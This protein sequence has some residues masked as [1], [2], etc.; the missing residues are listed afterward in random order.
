MKSLFTKPVK[1]NNSFIAQYSPVTACLACFLILFAL[2]I[3]NCDSFSGGSV[4]EFIAFNTG[5]ASVKNWS[6]VADTKHSKI[7]DKWIHYPNSDALIDI[8]VQL[9]NPLD[10]DLNLE[11]VIREYNGSDWLWTETPPPN[12]PLKITRVNNSTVKLRI[13][14]TTN[15]L[16]KGDSFKIRIYITSRDGTRDFGY[17]DLPQ[18]VYD[19]QLYPAFKLGIDTSIPKQPMA[20]WE[21]QNK[22]EHIGINKISLL[23]VSKNSDFQKGEWI[24]RY[25]RDTEEWNLTN[26][27]TAVIEGYGM[28]NPGIDKKSFSLPFPMEGSTDF[29]YFSDNYDFFVTVEDKNGVVVKASLNGVNDLLCMEN[30]RVEHKVRS[31]D[32]YVYEDDPFFVYKSGVAKYY[33]IVPYAVDGIRITATKQ[34]PDNQKVAFVP[35]T[36][37]ESGPVT[38]GLSKIGALNDIIMKVDWMDTESGTAETNTLYTFSVYRNLPDRDSA[39]KALQV[40]GDDGK[41]YS[42]SPLFVKPSDLASEQNDIINNYTV[43]VP[44][45]VGKVSFEWN[46]LST[47]VVTSRPAGGQ[48]NDCINPVSDGVIRDPFY[49]GSFSSP[50]TDPTLFGRSSFSENDWFYYTEDNYRYNYNPAYIVEK[51]KWICTKLNYS[52]F[53]Y[54]FPDYGNIS[55]LEIMKSESVDYIVAEGE[56]NFEINVEPQNDN[57]DSRVYNVKVIRAVVN[58]NTDARLSALT[59]SSGVFTSVFNGGIFSYTLNVPHGTSSVTLDATAVAGAKIIEVNS[60]AAVQPVWTYNESTRVARTTINGIAPNMT[61]VVTFKVAGGP[62]GSLPN[63]Y[64]VRI[65]GNLPALFPVPTLKGGDRSLTVTLTAE[66]DGASAY[67]VWYNTNSSNSGNVPNANAIKAAGTF[68]YINGTSGIVIPGLNNY[69]KYKVWVRGINPKTNPENLI[70]GDWTLAENSGNNGIPGPALLRAATGLGF[71][72]DPVGLYKLDPA[73]NPNTYT[74]K[75]YVHSDTETVTISALQPAGNNIAPVIEDGNQLSSLT[76]GVFMPAKTITAFSPDGKTSQPY[77]VQVLKNLAPPKNLKAIGYDGRVSLSWTTI[78]DV[79]V[80]EIEY[81]VFYHNQPIS[82]PDDIAGTASKWIGNINHASGTANISPLNNHQT[83]YFWVRGVKTDNKIPGEWSERDNAIPKSDNNL[84]SGLSFS[85]AAGTLEPGFNPTI[86][87]YSLIMES[88]ASALTITG[89]KAEPNQT[90]SYKFISDAGF[91]TTPITVEPT[92]LKK[93]EVIIEVKSDSGILKEYKITAY[94]KPATYSGTYM[95]ATGL[96]GRVELNWTAHSDPNVSAYEV[97]YGKSASSVSAVK[98]GAD[99]PAGTLKT[100]VSGLTNGDKYYFWLKAKNADGKP[101]NFPSSGVP[102]TPNADKPEITIAFAFPDENPLQ[103]TVVTLPINPSW[104]SNLPLNFIAPS[105]YA[106]YQWFI[107]GKAESTANSFSKNV[108]EF[109]IGEHSV[110]VRFNYSDGNMINQIFSITGVFTVSP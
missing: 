56:N 106:P 37:E 38:R 67:E 16:T 73:F 60:D 109:G 93:E 94:R 103:D 28:L 6:F 59:G 3:T 102:A 10:Y 17:H 76:P 50:P 107:D 27:Q 66:S 100:T 97:F 31:S 92:T 110:T 20:I 40:F 15:R 99:I 44:N 22:D 95:T 61:R 2:L 5:N 32:S 86:F 71:T 35:N 81:E 72:L 53:Y 80:S 42:L 25:N 96:N 29:Q 105:G 90:V 8:D 88:G 49:L 9:D 12:I 87:E 19:T 82:N 98:W 101:G 75:L 55:S 47:S 63:N 48:W 4:S 83:Y 43:F 52:T 69:T 26:D 7:D 108:R 34:F 77:T 13:G 64:T 46:Y 68:T 14:D 54:Y 89:E 41:S 84:L 51:D 57:H 58:G 39:L 1:R 79:N 23:F 33:L 21:I 65:N 74:Y 18:I 85:H 30:I 70:T 62:Q 78:P 91:N 11:A 104:S 45:S 36:F 24:Y